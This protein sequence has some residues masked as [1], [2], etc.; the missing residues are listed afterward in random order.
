MTCT[1]CKNTTATC[2]SNCYP[3]SEFKQD[4]ADNLEKEFLNSMPD[5]MKA[6]WGV[7]EEKPIFDFIRNKRQ[8]W[9][10]EGMDS[11]KQMLIPIE[12]AEKIAYE[13]GKE[14]RLASTYK[15]SK[16]YLMGYEEGRKEGE[17]NF[18]KK[19]GK[20][21]KL[22]GRKIAIQQADTRYI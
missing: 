22:R 18:Y 7:N 1:L 2:C 16:V 6:Q 8:K 10:E 20:N 15:S 3:P 4:T 17:Q 21:I 12:E 13:K 11:I 5:Y 19:Y 9:I 14:E